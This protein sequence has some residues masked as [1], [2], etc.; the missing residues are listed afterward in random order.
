MNIKNIPLHLILCLCIIFVSNNTYSQTKQ[1]K[2]DLR[3]E[4][5]NMFA[6]IN[7]QS[8]P[9]GLLRDY[10]EEYED[11]DCFTGS[12]PLTEQNIVDKKTYGYLLS[13]IKS[14]DL[15]GTISNGIDNYFHQRNKNDENNSISLSIALYKYS[16]IK[17]NAL[18]DGL[19]VYKDKQVYNTNKNPYRQDYLFICCPNI[20]STTTSSI[21]LNLSKEKL[22]TN[23]HINKFEINTGNGFHEIEAS[24]SVKVNLKQGKNEI[25]IKAV[26]D[27]G[28]A[29]LS[30]TSIA[31]NEHKLDEKSRAFGFNTK[32]NY[33]SGSKTI[34]GED[35]RGISTKAEVTWCL[36]SGHN[37]I[38][39]PF[40]VVEGFDPRFPS[41]PK[42]FWS[43]ESKIA[44]SLFFKNLRDNCNYDIIY[45]DWENPNEY[46]QANAYTLISIIKWI[47]EQKAKANSKEKN[48]ILGHSMGGII[49]RY[50]LKT[51]ENKGIKH[52]TQAYISYDS[53]HLGANVPLGVLYGYK[54]VRDWC[55]D[56][57]FLKSI[58]RNIGG[59]E[60]NVDELIQLGNS[61][62]YSNATAQ[63]LVDYV[64]QE[65][66]VDNR[67]YILWQKELNNL[68][69]PKG[70]DGNGL[71]M[72]AVANGSYKPSTV[73][74]HYLT[75]DGNAGVGLF[76]L[77]CPII[78]AAAYGLSLN[79]ITA[80]LV[81]LI[82]GK[83][84]VD[85]EIRISPAK[86]V[87]DEITHINIKIKKKFLWI[88]PTITHTNFSFD[89]YY[90]NIPLFDT[91]PSSKYDI[92]GFMGD[93]EGNLGDKLDV[94][95]ELLQRELYIKA[96]GIPFVP[97]S[98]A[99]AIGAGLSHNPDLYTS[100]P[101]EVL[102]AFGKNYF[103]H[104]ES[105]EHAIISNDAEKWIKSRLSTSIV[106]PVNGYTNAK[107]TLSNTFGPIDWKT[108]NSEI[109]T[110]NSNGM[111]TTKGK[112]I[113]YIEAY[114]N[115]IKYSMPIAVGKPR[116]IIQGTY[117]PG[118]YYV[119][120]ECIDEE[121]KNIQNLVNNAFKFKWGIKYGNNSIEWL[122]NNVPEIL[123]KQN[124]DNEHC[125]CFLEVLNNQEERISLQNMEISSQNV[126]DI[127]NSVF[128][129]DRNGI[130]YDGLKNKYDFDYACIY[131]SRKENL[132]PKYNDRSW[133]AVT[134][135]SVDPSGKTAEVTIDDESIALKDMFSK[136]AIDYM[137]LNSDENQEYVYTIVLLNYENKSLQYMPIRII[138]K[139][140]I[141]K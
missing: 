81:S 51:M 107:Y 40:I 75:A 38:E 62:A 25:I 114:H 61:L 54:A 108:S 15:I 119:K 70:D 57:D 11:L 132:S 42:G 27:N 2:S 58:I 73:P 66:N 72:L 37:R 56:K 82:P 21:N 100:E 130:L 97:T 133:G 39:K 93:I 32:Y 117:K 67:E 102:S 59:E 23:T 7:R 44:N 4:L 3:K 24:Q 14:A 29:L 92:K 118:G 115:G 17:E 109:A 53:P 126:Y 99:L 106:G 74:D 34:I 141:N 134:A 91:Y 85:A 103:I 13:T 87:G 12:A 50:A 78:P 112:G 55:A 49:A 129:I 121:F 84:K 46:I 68:G 86:N 52:Q 28:K 35:Y 16:Q 140:D 101:Q 95:Y 79:D 77:I 136:E 8:V 94:S 48:T 71:N 64:N 5:N 104:N 111:L 98:S 22:L 90:P 36:A 43:F 33:P 9:T 123:F 83:T 122:K 69:F 139:S 80:A 116:Y 41:T 125:I 124:T 1:E 105:Q 88:G 110:I 137:K 63:L 6:K 20:E 89:R 19:I 65:G 45:I 138:Y 31:L 47:N 60:Y 76:D 18:K 30:H 96:S 127:E 135:L 131:F 10:A 120:T 26:L 113:C 128:Y